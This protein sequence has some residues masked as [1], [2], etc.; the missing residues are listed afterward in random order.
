MVYPPEANAGFV[1]CME[2]VPGVYTKGRDEKRPLVCMDEGSV[3]G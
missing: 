3:T 2:D 1:A